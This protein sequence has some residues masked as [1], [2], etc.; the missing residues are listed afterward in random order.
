MGHGVPLPV[1]I[2]RAE[3]EQRQRGVHSGPVSPYFAESG[4]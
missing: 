2:G 1:H 4:T 3:V